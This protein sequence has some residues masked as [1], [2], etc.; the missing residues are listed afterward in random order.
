MAQ[1]LADRARPAQEERSDVYRPLPTVQDFY[2]DLQGQATHTL[3]AHVKNQL[4]RNPL[5]VLRDGKGQ[6]RVRVLGALDYVINAEKRSVWVEPSP[7]S[8][9]ERRSKAIPPWGGCHP[10]KPLFKVDLLN[11]LCRPAWLHYVAARP[12]WFTNPFARHQFRQ[13]HLFLEPR[14]C[15]QLM[16]DATHAAFKQLHRYPAL[17]QLQRDIAAT[18]TAQLGTELVELSLRSR[19]HLHNASLNAEHFNRVWQNQP[20][21]E[22]MAL[23]NPRLLSALAAWMDEGGFLLV[24]N[25]VD[26]LPA[27]R[28]DLLSAGLPP[29]AWRVLA[30]HG[31]HKLLPHRCTRDHWSTMVK[32]LH[33]LQHAHWPPVPP[34]KLLGL[35]VDAA[36]YPK[37]YTTDGEHIPGWFWQMTCQEANLLRNDARTYA[38][39][40]DQLP[41][42][43]FMV[44][45]WQPEPDANQMR[46][47]IT[48]L[49][50]QT[51]IFLMLRNARQAPP[52]Y[53]WLPTPPVQNLGAQTAWVPLR[54]PRDLLTEAMALHNCADSYED[55]CAAGTHLLISLRHH[56]T[57]KRLALASMQLKE[58]GWELTRVAGPCNRMVSTALHDQARRALDWVMF[59]SRSALHES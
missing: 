37:R 55:K 29:K 36:G 22:T 50:N 54:S 21:F 16:F 3:V 48:W 47:G 13:R 46:R 49:Q 34:R 15:V 39:L 51:G 19:V 27:M 58:E 40:I 10:T 9:G 14:S 25:K 8:A 52:W 2:E 53:P 24:D 18:L 1:A 44:R 38:A 57:G 28:R 41:Q 26:A 42:H 11:P 20:L 45:A 59:Q 5:K 30:H 43:C 32:T 31:L 6:L 17:A 56:Q 23:E 35:L 12:G 7:L 4:Q 33:A